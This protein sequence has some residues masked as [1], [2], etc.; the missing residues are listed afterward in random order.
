MKTSG[1]INE[2]WHGG[3]SF[4]PFYAVLLCVW[5]LNEAWALQ[6]DSV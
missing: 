5:K 3:G 6:S 4:P 2:C 1:V